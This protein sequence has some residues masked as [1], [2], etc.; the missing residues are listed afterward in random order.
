MKV[1]RRLPA[2]QGSGAG[3]AGWTRLHGI[4]ATTFGAPVDRYVFDARGFKLTA[5][6]ARDQRLGLGARTRVQRD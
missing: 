4:G 2:V 5:R 1:V 6:A 3:R